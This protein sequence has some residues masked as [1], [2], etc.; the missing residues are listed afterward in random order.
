[1][2]VNKRARGH[3]L[4]E[5]TVA[6][7]CYS[8]IIIITM[9]LFRGAQDVFRRVSSNDR[10]ARELR[11]AH[12]NISRDLCLSTPTGVAM[13]NVTVGGFGVVG[14]ALWFRSPYNPK[15]QKIARKPDGSALY[16]RNVLYYMT[17]PVN[18]DAL[19]GQSCSPTAG[20]GN[21]ND[22]CPH[23]MLIRKVIDTGTPSTTIDQSAE[24]PLIPN[25]SGY[26]SRPTGTTIP[27]EAGVEERRVI[28]QLLLHFSAVRSPAPNNFPREVAIDLRAV[29]IDEAKRIAKVGYDSFMSPARSTLVQESPFS[30]FLRN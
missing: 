11:Q 7:A 29:S 20:P 8:A 28:S 10:A 23:K 18:H 6:V 16:Q 24:E 13:T 12:V 4:L 25:I 17:V 19:Y 9:M 3:S 22:R 5:M 30:V 14:Q 26:L 1:M 2:R 27:G 15:E 21:W